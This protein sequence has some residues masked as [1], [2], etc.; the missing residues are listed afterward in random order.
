VDE[1]TRLHSSFATHF[2][3]NRLQ[4]LVKPCV[5]PEL[6]RIEVALETFL[7]L[8]YRQFLSLNGPLFLPDLW[9]EVV[10]RELDVHPLREF[11]TPSE[12]IADTRLY[13]SGG[14]PRDFVGV[15]GDFMGNLFGFQKV[16]RCGPRPDDVPVS[17]FDHDY[18]HVV[19]VAES[20]D[21]WIDW[22]V[23]NLQPG[24]RPVM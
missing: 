5:L 14:M 10:K 17:L 24:R 15:A 6:D 13:W 3:F 11:L 23:A 18:C 21:A 22:F 20:F 12:V 7:P 1:R 4:G 9:D 8:A 19:P 2:A 16:A